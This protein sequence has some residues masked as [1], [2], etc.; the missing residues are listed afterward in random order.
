[1]PQTFG[2]KRF[3]F[4]LYALALLV[5]FYAVMDFKSSSN[6]AGVIGNRKAVHITLFCIINLLALYYVYSNLKFGFFI[7]PIENSLWLITIWV[8]V[9]NLFT[10]GNDRW[11][12]AIHMGLSCLWILTYHFFSFYIRRWPNS[13]KHIMSFHTLMFFFY[14]FSALYATHYLHNYL[15]QRGYDQFA[16]VNL[17]YNV[18][19][20]LPWVFMVRQ[21]WIRAAGIALV[22]LVIAISMKRGAIV[23]FPLMLG[24]AVIIE[25]FVKRKS[26]GRSLIWIILLI[27]IIY[28]GFFIANQFSGGFLSKRFSME[29]LADGSGRS[30]MYIAGVE[31]ILNWPMMDLVFGKGSGSTLRFFGTGAHNEWLEFTF[32]FGLVGMMLYALFLFTVSRQA[33]RLT[34]IRSPYAP[35]YAIIVINYVVLGMYSGVYFMHS[36]FFLV[37]LLGAVKG[38]ASSSLK[39]RGRRI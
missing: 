32:N 4:F 33:L 24:V 28:S 3:F 7:S 14:T 2:K 26:L 12:T 9:V 35:A 13:L 18:L 29:N 36:S 16:V 19:V 15:I 30:H 39:N 11:I 22:F 10:V 38:L 1:M 8:G 17:S 6:V 34:M 23:V 25:S 37:A 5:L 21:Q 20:F 31:A 27:V